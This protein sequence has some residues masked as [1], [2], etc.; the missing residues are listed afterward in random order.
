MYRKCYIIT[1]SLFTID[2]TNAD[3]TEIAPQSSFLPKYGKKD[4]PTSTKKLTPRALSAIATR[5]DKMS[6]HF[7]VP[8]AVAL[9]SLRFLPRKNERCS[10]QFISRHG[11][12]LAVNWK[13][14][15]KKRGYR[16]ETRKRAFSRT[17]QEQ[18]RFRAV[19]QRTI[20]D[21]RRCTCR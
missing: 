9:Y 2:I 7:A 21:H 19:T 14:E 1:T 8:L 20:A 16:D 5:T 18:S 11:R 15:R 12:A 6:S 3:E 13:C 10:R 17:S 4:H